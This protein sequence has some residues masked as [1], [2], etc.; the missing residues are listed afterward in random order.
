MPALGFPK[1]WR[2]ALDTTFGKRAGRRSMIC[3]IAAGGLSC[4]QFSDRVP[5]LPRLLCLLF[6]ALTLAGC[7]RPGPSSL[8]QVERPEGAKVVTILVASDRVPADDRFHSFTAG[9]SDRLRYS[10]VSISIPPDHR[11]PKIEWPQGRPD[12]RHSFAVVG[13]RDL[14][15]AEFVYAAKRITQTSAKGATAGLFVHGFNYTYQEALFRLAQ[16][17][18]DSGVQGPPILFDWPSQGEV[19]GYVA[20]R[21]SAAFAR[22]DL[23]TVLSDLS[24][25]GVKTTMLAHSMGAWLAVEAVRQLSLM[26][27]RDVI[28]SVDQLVLAA[29]DIDIDLLKRQLAATERL[30]KPIVILASKD[31]IALALSKRLAGSAATAGSLDVDDPRTRELALKENLDIVD[32]SK[33]PTLNGSNHDRFAALAAVYPHLRQGFSNPVAGTGAIV[34]NGVGSAVSAPFRLGGSLLAQ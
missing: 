18:A 14:T 27:R 16:M 28:R 1:G 30:R 23:V 12:P 10:E 7:A 25:G 15:S 31:D 6:L 17:A 22:D 20:D 3:A 4:R 33:L 13:R 29:P 8:V 32:I 11:P 26:G 34:L 2:C 21:D 9:R 19:T 24:G 5:P